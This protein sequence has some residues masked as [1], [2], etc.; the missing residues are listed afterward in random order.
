MRTPLI[1]L[2]LIGILVGTS[3]GLWVYSKL[4][5]DERE[6]ELSRAI[7]S[8]EALEAHCRE[9]IGEP[10]IV[11]VGERILV[12]TGY[13]LANII[14]VRTDEGNI[15][16]DAGMNMERALE[17][18]DALLQRAPG[19]IRALIFTHSH[20]DHIGGAAA[21][22]EEQ[23]EIWATKNFNDHFIKQYGVLRPIET[24]RGARQF[25]SSVDYA[26]L[27]CSALGRRVDLLGS[28]KPGVRFPTH[29]FEGSASLKIGGLELQLVEAHGETH[30]QLFVYIPELEALF[31]GDN[32]YLAF[33]NLYTIRGTAPRDVPRWIES[34]DR[35]RRLDPARLIPSHTLPIDGRDEVRAALRDYRDAIQSIYDQVIRYANDGFDLDAIV[36]RLALPSSLASNRALLEL[37]GQIDWSGRA[38]FGNALGWFDGRPEALYPS[39]R[40]DYAEKMIVNLGGTARTL[41]LAIEARE[42]DDP[43]YA[44]ELLA[45][46]RDAGE[47]DDAARAE[48]IKTLRRLAQDIANTNGRGYLLER[49]LELEGHA[50]V[51]D[52]PELDEELV[53]AIPPETILDVM[54]S[55]LIPERAVDVEESLEIELSDRSVRHQLAIRNGVLELAV[56]DPLP[57]S[58]HPNAKMR[59][60][61]R[62]FQELGLGVKSPAALIAAGEL[63]LEGDPLFIARFFQRFRQGI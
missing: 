53:R 17:A 46:L 33:P 7:P 50:K 2:A 18:R 31:P 30:D 42:G 27:P 59:L 19:A 58:L 26:S 5:I 51:P 54:R 38:I 47:L 25:G 37:Y 48:L 24:I 60:S 34:L 29:H 62:A 14:L 35:M 57:G 32:Y 11:E 43:R 10:R 40:P 4:R 52:V 41:A 49:A 23:T 13:D 1:A 9:I 15:I 61:G 45:L 16:I 22:A 20:I 12:A 44:L 21:F 56:G 39:A 55:R 63:E 6:P 28:M 36:E 8:E 3:F